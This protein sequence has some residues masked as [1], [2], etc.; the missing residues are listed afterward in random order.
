MRALLPPNLYRI[1]PDAH[2]SVFADF[3]Y[4]DQDMTLVG[5]AVATDG[6]VEIAISTSQLGESNLQAASTE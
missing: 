2:V 4:K 1:T 5:L 6:K 3:G